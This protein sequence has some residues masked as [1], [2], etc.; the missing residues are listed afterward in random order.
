MELKQFLQECVKG[1]YPLVSLLFIPVFS[2]LVSSLPP[3][4]SPSRKYMP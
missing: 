4:P 2:D 1:D 3:L